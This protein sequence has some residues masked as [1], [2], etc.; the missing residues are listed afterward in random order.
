MDGREDNK[1][2][3]KR[4]KQHG[5][6]KCPAAS[7][8]PWITADIGEDVP[9]VPVADCRISERT[10]FLWSY[11]APHFFSRVCACIAEHS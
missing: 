5:K 10:M 7:H 1:I 8:G 4:L 2:A 6:P 3:D 9:K 11:E